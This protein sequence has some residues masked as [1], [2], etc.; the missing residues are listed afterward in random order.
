MR[1]FE[2]W[3]VL[4][5]WTAVA[6]AQALG[7]ISPLPTQCPP[8]GLPIRPASPGPGKK[9]TLAQQEASYITNRERSVLPSMWDQYL[10]NVKRSTTSPT[11]T[12][13]STLDSE[14]PPLR[15]RVGFAPSGGAFRSAALTAGVISAFD[16]RNSTSVKIGTGGIFQLFSYASST[17]GS[18]WIMESFLQAGEPTIPNLIFPPPNPNVNNTNTFGGWLL[19]FDLIQP[20]GNNINLTI[21]FFEIVLE[22]VASK[23]K[24]G[25]PVTMTD[26]FQQLLSRHF[27]NGTTADNFFQLSTHGEGITLSGLLSSPQMET[28]TSPFLIAVADSIPPTSN[29]NHVQASQGSVPITGNEAWELSPVEVGSFNPQLGEF[30]P[31]HLLGSTAG[32]NHCIAGFDQLAY[33]IATSSSVFTVNNGATS[34]TFL[35]ST[36]YNVVSGILLS[37]V[38]LLAELLDTALGPQTGIRLDAAAVP[39]PFKGINPATYSNTNEDIVYLVDG[40]L[41]GRNIAYEPLT[42]RARGLDVIIS[43]DAASYWEKLGDYRKLTFSANT[44]DNFPNGTSVINAATGAKQFP[45]VYAFP[46]VPSTTEIFVADKLNLFPTFFGCFEGDKSV[47]II[48]YIPNHP[49]EGQ[50]PLTNISDQQNHFAMDEFQAILDQAFEI[51]ITGRPGTSGT[52][53]PEC[54][55]CALVDRGNAKL[56]QTKLWD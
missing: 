33:V 54:L 11:S 9:Q 15:S 28:F 18:S 29:P 19:Q 34:F 24:V 23:I 45:D 31:T 2:F 41:D 16:G 30:I 36:Y 22:E 32:T 56:D 3:L 25:L 20:L 10:C 44:I 17:S 53:W 35:S 1:G 27:V 4:L 39:N 8:S 13:Q 42:V 51:A 52:T 50:V 47:P 21:E 40:G 37:P 48:V 5:S 55:E 14:S 7:P 43:V 49:I 6:M 26:I 38:D 12:C 46:T